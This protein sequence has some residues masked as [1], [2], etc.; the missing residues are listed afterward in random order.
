[1]RN[2]GFTLTELM[3]T[4]AIVAILAAIAY[5]S[6]Q[7]YVVTTRRSAAEAC[8]MEL[9]QFMERYYTTHLTY[10]GA[11][12]PNTACRNDLAGQYT[13]SFVGTPDASTF[14]VQAVAAGAQATQDAACTP[15][16]VTHTGARTPANCW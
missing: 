8:L 1:M 7:R 12:L 9:A 4:V 5:P 6:Y 15:L 2:K 3:I 16:T 14:T 10:T 13:F 11:T